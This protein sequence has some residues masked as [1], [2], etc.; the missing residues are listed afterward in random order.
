MRAVDQKPEY[1]LEW[2]KENNT[3]VQWRIQGEFQGSKGTSL[4]LRILE[5]IFSDLQSFTVIFYL[6]Y[7]CTKVNTCMQST[8][9]GT[10]A[11]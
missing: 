9:E 3:S 1:H 6:F 11:S 4:L 2:P 7:R 8:L 5:L 10:E